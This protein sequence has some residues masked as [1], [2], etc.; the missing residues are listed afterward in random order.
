MNYLKNKDEASCMFM[1]IPFLS[2]LPTSHQLAVRAKPRR[3]SQPQLQR[4]TKASTITSTNTT[5]TAIATL[6]IF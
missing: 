6:H 4:L 5:A 1:D 2:S 3:S